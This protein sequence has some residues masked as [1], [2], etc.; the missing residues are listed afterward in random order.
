MGAHK[1]KARLLI[2]RKRYELALKELGEALREDPKDSESYVLLG[3]CLHHQ[4]KHEESLEAFRKAISLEPEAS[5]AH[6]YLGWTFFDRSL[7]EKIHTTELLSWARGA[8]EEALRLT[9]EHPGYLS[10]LATILFNQQKVKK[11]LA[12]AEK[13]LALDPNHQG[14]LHIR[15]LALSELEKSSQAR[16]TIEKSLVIDSGEHSTFTVRGWV[17]WNKSQYKNALESF[18]EALRLDAMDEWAQNGFRVATL[19]QN[20][21]TGLAYTYRR[22]YPKWI[23]RIL[24]AAALFFIGAWFFPKPWLE[25]PAVWTGFL[26]ILMIVLLNIARFYLF[27]LEQGIAVR[28]SMAD[29]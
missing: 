15:S 20:P 13:G 8:V 10:L 22:L 5:Y 17:Y 4:E 14:C 9:P 24:A 26:V 2:Q 25:A 28:H 18:E 11:A 3:Q 16:E 21:V 12:T 23:W 19:A 1:E 6:Y 7:Q 27:S 29:S